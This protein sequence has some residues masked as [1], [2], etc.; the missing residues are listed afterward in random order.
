MFIELTRRSN[1]KK[2][3]VSKNAIG[4]MEELGN[5]EWI[6]EGFSKRGKWIESKI[7]R[8]TEINVFGTT[9]YVEE[10]IQEI[11]KMMEDNNGR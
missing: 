10:T 9:V 11:E 3:K 8:F 1:G 4:L 5:L 2:I 6:K 7:D